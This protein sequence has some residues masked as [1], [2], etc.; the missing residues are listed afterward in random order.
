MRR[1][2]LFICLVRLLPGWNARAVGNAP[3]PCLARWCGRVGLAPRGECVRQPWFPGSRAGTSRS[4]V[5]TACIAGT[6]ETDRTCHVGCPESIREPSQRTCRL[7][8]SSRSSIAPCTLPSG[9][10][11]LD[12]ATPAPS[13]ERCHVPCCG[14]AQAPVPGVAAGSNDESSR[15]VPGIRQVAGS[16]CQIALRGLHPPLRRADDGLDRQPLPRL[17]PP[18]GAACAAV[19][20][21]GARQRRDPRRPGEAAGNGPG[22]TSRRAAARR[23]RAGA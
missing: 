17:P 19:L 9:G 5:T 6:R 13:A 14:P 10:F 11:E 2:E 18:A 3:R 1:T 20:G 22:R 7:S 15:A 16:A 8:P 23:Q 12:E 4:E 21:D